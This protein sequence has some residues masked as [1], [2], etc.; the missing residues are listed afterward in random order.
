MGALLDDH[1]LVNDRDQ[2]R[3]ADCREAVGDGDRGAALLGHDFRRGCLVEQQDVGLAHQRPCDGHALLLTARQLTAADA[4]LGVVPV[5]QH[6]GDEGVRVGRARR[7]LNL[8]L[9]HAVHLAIADVLGHGAH[10]EHR[11]LPNQPEARAEPFYVE[12]AD[13]NAIEQDAPGVG[14]VEA[15]DQRDERRLAASGRA[16]QRRRLAGRDRERVAVADL[17]V[18]A[19]GERDAVS[20]LKEGGGG[21]GRLLGVGGHAGGAAERGGHHEHHH[22]GDEEAVGGREGDGRRARV[23]R[24]VGRRPAEGVLGLGVDAPHAKLED[25]AKEHGDGALGETRQ[26]GDGQVAPARAHGG[27]GHDAAVVFI[28]PMLGSEGGDGPDAQHNLADERAGRLGALAVG[29]GS[30]LVVGGVVADGAAGEEDDL[31]RH[32]DAHH[33][34]RRQHHQAHQR[35]AKDEHERQAPR[36]HADEAA[37]RRQ[38]L[39]VHR[40]DERHALAKELG[41]LPRRVDLLVEE[42]N[43]HRQPFLHRARTQIAG[44]VLAGDAKAGAL[45]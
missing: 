32:G 27:G 35:V 11:L 43:L 24:R 44:Q 40:L 26:E 34:Q 17:E 9:R 39:S 45:E 38:L 41:E 22:Q 29:A 19:G 7:L 37:G 12:L 18:A 33:R 15:L 14:L 10:E 30:G 42:A 6:L 21:G 2:V 5:L 1:A 13:V 31:E 4:H 20:T 16:A 8:F 3:I 28:E 36:E 25:R 23:G